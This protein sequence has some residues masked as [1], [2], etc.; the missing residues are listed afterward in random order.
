MEVST[1]SEPPDKVMHDATHVNKATA[2]AKGS[3]SFREVVASSSQWF[4]EA[5]KIVSASRDW[6]DGDELSPEGGLAVKFDKLTLDRLRSPWRLTL[7]GKCLGIKVRSAYMES[8][9][10]AMWRIKGS[11]EVIDVGHDVFLFR[12]TQPDDFERALFGGPW[13]IL[14]HYLMISTW[15]P[16]FRPSKDGFDTMSVWIRIDELPV[17]YYDKEALFAIAQLVGKPI[18]VDY[19]TDKVTRGRYA[20]VCVEIM[21]SKPLITKVWIGGA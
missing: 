15:K 12:F 6:E 19:A 1:P 10:R 21:L 14:D 9:V 4:A 13:F 11:L 8:R 2:Q 20:R 3:Q 18:R 5:R 7:M 16:N 17:E